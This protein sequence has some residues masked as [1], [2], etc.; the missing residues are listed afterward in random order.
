MLP[1]PMWEL[2]IKHGIYVLATGDPGQLPPIAEEDDNHVL[3]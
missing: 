1:K 2:L 3:E